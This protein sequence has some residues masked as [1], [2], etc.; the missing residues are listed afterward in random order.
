MELYGKRIIIISILILLLSLL[1][2][3]DNK[4]VALFNLQEDGN[5]ELFVDLVSPIIEI[6]LIYWALRTGKEILNR[7]IENIKQIA[8]QDALTG[9][10]N[11]RAFMDKLHDL[12]SDKDTTRFGLMFI[13]LDGFKKVNDQLGHDV[14]DIL[15]QH[16]S[17]Y[18]QKSVAPKDTVARLAGDEFMVILPNANKNESI[19]V[20][21]RIIQNFKSTNK[22]M[23]ENVVVTPS[24][25]IA[26]YPQNTDKPMELI[27][28]ADIAMYQ[29]KQ[30][31]KNSYQIYQH[32]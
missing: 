22:I 31:G 2:F 10:P 15:L 28:Y 16:V 6:F 20:A 23:G 19:M 8:F 14:G 4:I 17:D 21:N 30:S 24:I 18:L 27:K 11:R 3:F 12:M 32:E 5:F 9:L 26:L 25:G 7:E 1:D 29:A 13:D